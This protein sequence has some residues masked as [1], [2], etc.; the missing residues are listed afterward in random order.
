VNRLLSL[1][2][3]IVIVALHIAL[4]SVFEFFEQHEKPFVDSRELSLIFDLADNSPGELVTETAP[5]PPQK[6][7]QEEARVVPLAAVPLPREDVFLPEPAI[8]EIPVPE[9]EPAAGVGS[10]AE[11]ETVAFSGTAVSAPAEGAADTGHTTSSV[12]LRSEPKGKS[13]MTDAEYLALVM[14]RLEQ[15]KIYPLSV[16]KRGIEGDIMVA[17]IIQ[18]DGSVSDMKLADPV[19]HRFLVQAAFETI[20]SASPFPVMEGRD[21]DYTAQVCIRYRLEDQHSQKK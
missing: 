7:A 12:R 13:P 5:K 1:A 21:G 17:F 8:Q 11:P 10:Q 3:F 9:E 16:R 4:L 18:R 14:G 19:G 20:R 6:T 15:N 2:C